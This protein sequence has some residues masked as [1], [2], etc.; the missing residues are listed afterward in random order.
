FRS[1][2]CQASSPVRRISQ[3]TIEQYHDHFYFIFTANGFLHHMVRNMVGALVSIGQGK[4]PPDRIKQ[5]IKQRDRRLG[6]ATFSP[7]GLYLA[8][9]TYPNEYNLPQLPWRT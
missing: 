6:S 4:Q 1:S 7:N 8:E 9:I 2:D 5:L 3:A